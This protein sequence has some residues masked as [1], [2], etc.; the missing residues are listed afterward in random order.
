MVLYGRVLVERLLVA[1]T[2]VERELHVDMVT[3]SWYK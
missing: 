2:S 1:V 3:A